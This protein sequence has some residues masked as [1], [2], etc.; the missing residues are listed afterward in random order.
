MSI[1]I[2]QECGANTTT[3]TTQVITPANPASGTIYSL[4]PNK[5]PYGSSANL[6]VTN[7]Q[8]NSAVTL[9][10]IPYL[11]DGT[12]MSQQVITVGSTDNGGN[13][14]KSVLVN[15]YQTAS[16][17]DVTVKINGIEAKSFA[18]LTGYGC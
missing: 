8:A 2:N 12:K 6:N 9:S 7:S 5:V 3:Q 1:S 4:S 10:V 14:A 17:Y 15:W 11:N 18:L 16:A 13:L